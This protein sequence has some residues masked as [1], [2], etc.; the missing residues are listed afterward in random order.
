MILTAQMHYY[1]YYATQMINQ[2]ADT[3]W[4]CA[5][6]FSNILLKSVC[7]CLTYWKKEDKLLPPHHGE[8][9]ETPAQNSSIRQCVDVFPD[10]DTLQSNVK[11]NR[12]GCEDVGMLGVSICP[13]WLLSGVRLGSMLPLVCYPTAVHLEG[14][15]L[16]TIQSLPINFLNLYVFKTAFCKAIDWVFYLFSF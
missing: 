12:C 16:S 3:N 14:D 2:I 13:V 6:T 4:F 1:K 10:I 15:W 7:K 5:K 8:N 11:W 9:C